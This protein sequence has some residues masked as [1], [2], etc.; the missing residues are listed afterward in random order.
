MQFL[1][2]P[3]EYGRS[4]DRLTFLE[5]DPTMARIAA[6]PDLFT[7]LRDSEAVIDIEIGDGRLLLERS[8]ERYDIIIVDA[9][10][11]DAIPAHLITMEALE[12]YSDRLTERGVVAYHVSN[13]HLD[14]SPIVARQAD[15][16][17]MAAVARV[18]TDLEAARV[19]EGKQASIWIVVAR[20]DRDLNALSEAGSWSRPV[21]DHRTPLWTDSFS[22]LLSSLR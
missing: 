21:V 1:A 3:A 7:F 13:R 20:S 15:A 10:S 22:N 17:D 5:I 14:L 4:G 8:E 6:D 12:L 18:D 19:A 2:H 11:S 9:F 16:L